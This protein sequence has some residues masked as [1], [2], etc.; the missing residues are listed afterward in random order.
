M[1]VWGGNEPLDNTVG[2][3]GLEATVFSCPHENAAAGGDVLY[4]SSC[5]TGRIAR[6]LLA[7]VAGHGSS[8][9]DLARTLRD[10]MRRYVNTLDQTEFVSALNKTFAAASDMGRFATAVVA[11]YWVDTDCLTACNAG[12][13]RPAWYRADTRSWSLLKDKARA[14]D[15]GS[16]GVVERE[17]DKGGPTNLP[18][19]ILDVSL[20]D[21][22][23]IRL[24]PGDVVLFYTDSITEASDEN[25][26]MLGE[27]GLL[28][29]LAGLDPSN[30]RELVRQLVAGVAAHRGG[31]PSDDDLTIM[32]LACSARRERAGFFKRLAASV[33]FVGIVA[34]RLV[35]GKAPIPWPEWSTENVWGTMIAS[36]NQRWGG[37]LH[38]GE[39]RR[40]R[41]AA[42]STG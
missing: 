8:V 38:R 33:R 39:V 22:I 32:A 30:P 24:G 19:G 15:E 27:Q 21:E 14:G 13:P 10:L 28:S 23:T 31:R 11:T 9:A 25:G 5:G 16:G 36:V 6:L 42:R 35:G 18:L 37:S 1:E 3:P 17:G 12:H 2:V 26:A 7:D 29:L 34:S 20:Y 41:G 4:I 40:G